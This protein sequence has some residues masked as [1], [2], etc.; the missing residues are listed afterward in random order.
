MT[1]G[2]RLSVVVA[3]PFH[4]EELAGL[5]ALGLALVAPERS[6]TPEELVGACAEADL[7]VVRD[8]PI[9][10]H[11][12]EKSTRLSMIARVG[13]GAGNVDVK[14]ASERGVIVTHTP[15]F[16]ATA[17][18]ERLIMLAS[19][20]DTR[21]LDEGSAHIARG[22]H[23]S[24]LGVVGDGEAAM[25]L[26]TVAVV[27]GMKV[28]MWSPTLT[29][30]RATEVGGRHVGSLEELLSTCRLVAVMGPTNS[31]DDGHIEAI[32]EGGTLLLGSPN[33]ELPIDAVMDRLRRETLD[34]LGL[35]DS[36]DASLKQRLESH[37]ARFLSER[38]LTSVNSRRNVDIMLTRSVSEFLQRKRMSLA[39]NLDPPQQSY[40]T[41]VFRHTM[42]AQ[43]LAALFSQLAEAGV[44]II[45][46]DSRAFSTEA[47]AITRVHVDA[48]PT[49]AVMTRLRTSRG[50]LGADTVE[51]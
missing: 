24:S 25:N 14:A 48:P 38:Q 47:S 46:I 20:A 37:G 26:V 4:E 12:I 18:A 50:V 42:S 51:P 6:L 43:M 27:M 15:N 36:I 19:L 39:L 28:R 22:L 5:H 23:L 32:A 7:V 17:R 13:H 10:R 34:V 29:I 9:L 35:H 21:L 41:L 49:P 1:N 30:A 40:T 33:T 16:D 11:L 3:D 2:H 45:G 8:S 31:L 44:R